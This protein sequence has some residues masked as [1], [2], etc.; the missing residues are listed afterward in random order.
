[1]AHEVQH[2]KFSRAMA[3]YQAD[4]ARMNE[5]AKS[6]PST[7]PGSPFVNAAVD[8]LKP[9]HRDKF[10]VYS[11][12]L[13]AMGSTE[14]GDNWDKLKEIG[15]KV[16]PYAKSYWD[17]T[18]TGGQIDTATNETLAE[19]DSGTGSGGGGGGSFSGDATSI[20]G[21]PI[22]DDPAAVDGDILTY[23][24]LTE[25]WM[26]RQF[27]DGNL[28]IGTGAPATARLQ[29]AAGTAA[30][31]TA[32]LKY[33]SGTNLTS[34][35][36]GATEYGGNRVSFTP[37]SIRKY[38]SL[39]SA[40]I[41]AT[42][43]VSNT[44]VPTT[45]WTGAIPAGS[46]DT[47]QSYVARV[48]GRY[49]AANGVDQLSLAIKVGATTALTV[50][51]TPAAVTNQPVM[52]EFTFTVRTTGAGGTAWGFVEAEVGTEVKAQAGTATFALDSTAAMDV[53]VVATWSAADPGNACSVDQG[54][55]LAL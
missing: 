15:H 48:M 30:A 23:D 11:A 22:D 26:I 17:A 7:G 49:S 4:R 24:T 19:L 47:G 41:T 32:P 52:L 27:I 8:V 16:S 12:Y 31:N 40:H 9:E 55:L 33:S 2:A 3:L 51:T 35:E 14:R 28:G 21:E 5:W 10:P 20:H 45:L 34:P 46:V 38:F 54:W 36:A 13:D 25:E 39:A 37:T 44:A 18:K 53:T 50:T 6:F 42:T 43:T 1:M 29:T